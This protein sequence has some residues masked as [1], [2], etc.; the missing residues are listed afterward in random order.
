MGMK[1]KRLFPAVLIAA[2][3]AWAVAEAKP[4]S[5]DKVRETARTKVAYE[6]KQSEKLYASGQ[7]KAAY[8]GHSIKQT[9]EIIDPV[10]KTVLAYLLDLSPKGYVV[11]S[12]DTDITILYLRILRRI[13]CC[14]W[15]E[16]T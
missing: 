10:T 16:W 3:W 6:Q 13:Y 7:L 11:V 9:R 1:I 2:G 14:T 15:S 5:A 8:Q 12:A 4:V